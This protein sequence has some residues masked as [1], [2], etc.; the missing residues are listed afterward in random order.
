[1]FQ[2]FIVE[3]G[4]KYASH[5]WRKASSLI[6]YAIQTERTNALQC[7][8]RAAVRKKKEKKRKWEGQGQ[9]GVM[10]LTQ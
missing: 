3:E 10:W 8:S 9:H 7:Q 4:R 2:Q 5:C 6:R 1:M